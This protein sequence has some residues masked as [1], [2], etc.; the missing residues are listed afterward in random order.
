[1]VPGFLKKIAVGAYLIYKSNGAAGVS[2]AFIR[3]G[4]ELVSITKVFE[5]L[6]PLILIN[7]VECGNSLF[8]KCGFRGSIL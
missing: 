6:N 3:A 5:L 4:F 7:R 1:M 8:Y 2:S